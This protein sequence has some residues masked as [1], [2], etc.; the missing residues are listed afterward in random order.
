MK[1]K[2][3]TALCAISAAILIGTPGSVY[4]EEKAV[5]TEAAATEKTDNV[6]EDGIYTAEF[7]TDSNMFHVNE[8]KDGKGILTVKDGEMT[9]HVSLVSKSIVNLFQG[10]KEDAEKEEAELLEPTTDEV[11]YSDGYTEEV[12]GFDIPVPVL[13][14]E[15]DVALL[16]KK[17]KWYDHKVSVSNPVPASEEEAEAFDGKTAKDLG[18]KEGNYTA[19]VSLEGGS[20]KA[21]VE[22]PAKLTVKD[23]E[24]T[25]VIKWSSPNY[26]YMVVDGEKYEMTNKEGN[27]TFEIPVAGFDADIFVKADTVAMSEP[28]EIDYTLKFDSESLKEEK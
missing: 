3:V 14:E 10:L 19:E 13:D 18:L 21:T 11:T 6:L 1:H 4:A 5:E 23:N 15:F 25:A 17:G 8:A 22:S 26:D 24:I 12:Y 27:S 9:I 28:H 7:D 16:G 2:L 20:G